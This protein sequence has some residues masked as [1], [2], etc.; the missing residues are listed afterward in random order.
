[1]SHNNMEGA[2][3]INIVNSCKNPQSLGKAISRVYENLQNLHKQKQAVIKSLAK[4]SGIIHSEKQCSNNVTSNKTAVFVKNLCTH[5]DIV[6]TMPSTKDE[7]TIR[8][9]VLPHR[10]S[11]RRPQNFY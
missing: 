2:T 1:M 5:P 8:E 11:G 4:K 3:V 10:V 9:K 7:I 6:Y